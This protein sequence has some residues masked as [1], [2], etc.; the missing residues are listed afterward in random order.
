MLAN[1]QTKFNE[2]PLAISALLLFAL[3]GAVLISALGFEHIGGY[4][5][6]PLCL[7]E[8]YAWYFTFAVSL[9]VFFGS[10]SKIDGGYLALLLMGLIGLGFLYN[11]YLAGYH[12]GIEWKWWAGPTSCAGD[13]L[14]KLGGGAGGLLEALNQTKVIRC[15]IAQFRLF[16]LSFSGYNFLLSLLA[17]AIALGTWIFVALRMKNNCHI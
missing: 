10:K 13:Q 14:N 6:C 15:D 2:N 1:L 4:K 7:L 11:A 17:G 16:G 9:L 3:S 8:R 12:A 5:P